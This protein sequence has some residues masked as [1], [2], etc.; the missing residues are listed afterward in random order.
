MENPAYR[1]VLHI[2]VVVLPTLILRSLELQGGD[3]WALVFVYSVG[4]TSIGAT[5]MRYAVVY[6]SIKDT[7]QAS[8]DTVNEV[9]FWSSIE[10]VFGATAFVLPTF[11][12]LGRRVF[13][14]LFP[15]PTSYG[16]SMNELDGGRRRKRPALTRGRWLTSMPA[17]LFLSTVATDPCDTDPDPGGDAES[18]YWLRNWSVVRISYSF[19]INAE[20]AGLRGSGRGIMT[21][22]KT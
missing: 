2:L 19:G 11:R 1:L 5:L 17:S 9:E 10:V 18:L 16:G 20:E 12:L 3:V 8:P 4:F 15:K 22:N 7:S 13:S 6:K 21:G 14:A